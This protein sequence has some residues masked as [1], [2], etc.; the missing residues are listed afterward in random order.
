MNKRVFIP[1]LKKIDHSTG[2]LYP[3]VMCI[4]CPREKANDEILKAVL[5][6]YSDA[7]DKQYMAF[8]VELI[9]QDN[10][11]GDRLGWLEDHAIIKRGRYDYILSNTDGGVF[12]G[13]I[14]DG[15]IGSDD[16]L[17]RK[18]IEFVENMDD[19]DLRDMVVRGHDMRTHQWVE[20]FPDGSVSETEEADNNTTHWIDYPNKA[21]ATIYSICRAGCGCNC[22]ICTMYSDFGSMEKDE[23]VERYS[24]DD[25]DYCNDNSLDEAILEYKRNN[26]GLSGEDIR[27]QMIDA[28]EEIEHGYFDDEK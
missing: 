24:E 5:H 10:F 23:F 28:I 18:A 17:R 19:N 13:M 7:Y 4:S 11:L 3:D 9:A 15:N 2:C 6:E 16:S 20:C 1:T 8:N 27:E 14:K 22:D 12:L 21:V 26:D 25:W